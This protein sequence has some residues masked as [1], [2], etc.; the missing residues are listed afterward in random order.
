MEAESSQAGGAQGTRAAEAGARAAPGDRAAPPKPLSRVREANPLRSLGEL[1][2]TSA[3][4]VSI[5]LVANEI[6]GQVAHSETF[7][8]LVS[9]PTKYS[10][11]RLVPSGVNSM[12]AAFF[13]IL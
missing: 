10:G 7:L 2:L 9:L 13:L 8:T 4:A 3:V 5:C 12:L 11:R 6:K 1:I